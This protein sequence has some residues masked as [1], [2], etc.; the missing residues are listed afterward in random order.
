LEKLEIDV[1]TLERGKKEIRKAIK[2]KGRSKVCFLKYECGC[3]P[4]HNSIRSGRRPDGSHPLKAVCMV[5]GK[6]FNC[7]EGQ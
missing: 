6:S 7:V 4:P 2:E 1:K 3:P 5:C